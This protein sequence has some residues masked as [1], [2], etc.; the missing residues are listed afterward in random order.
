MITRLSIITLSLFSHFRGLKGSRFFEGG[1][2]E[3]ALIW[4]GGYSR[5]RLI[6]ALQY[7]SH[8]CY[9]ELDLWTRP[10][11]LFDSNCAQSVIKWPWY[12]IPASPNLF[13]WYFIAKCF[14][15]Y[16]VSYAHL[17]ASI[18]Y[19]FTITS[20]VISHLTDSFTMGSYFSWYFYAISLSLKCLK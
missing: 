11:L 16:R 1:L 7:V 9:F 8:W 12:Y 15:S 17:I 20:D 5:G 18:S 3:G 14:D 6:K 2:F 4:G 19:S 13:L 10:N